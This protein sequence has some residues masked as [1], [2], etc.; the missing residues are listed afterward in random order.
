MIRRTVFLHIVRNHNQYVSP[1]FASFVSWTVRNVCAD[2]EPFD[3]NMPSRHLFQAP[4]QPGSETGRM[5]CVVQPR[6]LEV[7]LG[8]VTSPVLLATHLPGTLTKS[9]G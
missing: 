2:A 7:G 1:K 5:F 8:T 4:S 9:Q 6:V 3:G